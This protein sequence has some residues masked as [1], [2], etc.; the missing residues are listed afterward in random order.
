LKAKFSRG[1]HL[2][3]CARNRNLVAKDTLMG[4]TGMEN[5]DGNDEGPGVRCWK[6]AIGCSMLFAGHWS[7][8]AGIVNSESDLL[9]HD[10]KFWIS[11]GF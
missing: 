8:V 1:G 9:M 11:Y 6:L 5:E 4:A 2:L 7:L 3:F 10:D